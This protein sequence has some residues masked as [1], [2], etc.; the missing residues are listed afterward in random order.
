[1]GIEKKSSLG[2]VLSTVTDSSISDLVETA[3]TAESAGIDAIY[4]NEG[5]GDSLAAALAIALATSRIEVGTNITNIYFRHAYLAAHS[6]RAIAEVSRGRFILG[7]GMSHKGILKS[8]GI[9]MGNARDYLEEYVSQVKASLNGNTGE[10]FLK[11]TAAE[12]IPPVFVA[13]NTVESARI[14]GRVGDGLMPFLSPRNYLPELL[15]AANDAHRAEK[16]PC[17][18]SIPTFLH[19]D[20]AQARESARYNLAFFAMLPNYRKQW[21]RAGFTAAMNQ[22]QQQQAHLNRRELATLVPDELIDEVCIYGTREDCIA[23]ISAF[24]DAGADQVV[25]AVSPVNEDRGSATRRAI[26]QLANC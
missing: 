14:A 23:A 3:L 21:R 9:D 8:L 4:I 19:E 24:R 7:L 6:A 10:G 20:K 13:G 17:I 11:T 2:I 22:I 5:R 16:C 26:E 25:L 18:I 1:M 15:S 12:F